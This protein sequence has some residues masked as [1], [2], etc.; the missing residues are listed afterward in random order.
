MEVLVQITPR[1]MTMVH[2]RISQ[3]YKSIQTIFHTL[4]IAKEQI[5]FA[6]ANA[7]KIKSERKL[8][9]I[10]CINWKDQ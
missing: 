5:A 1:T 4:D 8:I 10:I 2:I 6:M 7:S 3:K 9:L